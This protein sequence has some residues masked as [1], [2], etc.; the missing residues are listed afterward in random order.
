MPIGE[1]LKE[2]FPFGTKYR[3]VIGYE[4]YFFDPVYVPKEK[5]HLYY[6]NYTACE[7]IIR[8][9]I[10]DIDIVKL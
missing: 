6:K 7:T 1:Y 5:E 9:G 2:V 8:D 3:L 10:R 4:G